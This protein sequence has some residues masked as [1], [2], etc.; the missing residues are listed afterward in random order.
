MIDPD[1]TP[2]RL[3]WMFADDLHTSPFCVPEAKAALADLWAHSA[4][5]VEQM[6]ASVQQR[7]ADPSSAA[8]P[9]SEVVPHYVDA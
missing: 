3:R 8:V 5:C 4:S 9:L 6:R 1:D 7:T 2:V